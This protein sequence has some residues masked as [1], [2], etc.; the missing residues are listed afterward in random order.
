MEKRDLVASACLPVG[1][2]LVLNCL[3]RGRVT[4]GETSWRRMLL[5]PLAMM[6]QIL[7]AAF[8]REK[9]PAHGRHYRAPGGFPSVR[10][11]GFHGA[12]HAFFL[13]GETGLL[14]T[15]SVEA[16]RSTVINRNSYL[17]RG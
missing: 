4:L 7:W 15:V 2:R 12:A 3:P 10:R 17:R 1:G 16:V 14:A 9:P 6:L 8:E 5:G 13:A 11:D